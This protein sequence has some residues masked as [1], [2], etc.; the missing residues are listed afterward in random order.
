VLI[1]RPTFESKYVDLK[2]PENL[3][4][5][6]PLQIKSSHK[7]NTLQLDQDEIIEI[8]DQAKAPE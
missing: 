5:K 6:N 2:S 8:L 3:L 4:R 1:E 7:N